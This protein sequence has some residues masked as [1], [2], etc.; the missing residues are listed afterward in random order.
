[1]PEQEIWNDIKGYEG[2][3]QVSNW[4]RVKSLNR[5]ITNR[6]GRKATIK[7]TI[8]KP[9]V[10]FDGYIRVHLSKNG[11]QKHYRVATLV[12]EAFNGPIPEGK[13][14]DHANGVRTDNRLENLRAVSHLE[15]CRNPISRAKHLAANESRSRKMKEYWRKKKAASK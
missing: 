6:R 13:E 5:I 14:L 2:R 1:M 9:E 7:E 11:K 10:V 3:Y 15:N 4:G 12:F 8:L